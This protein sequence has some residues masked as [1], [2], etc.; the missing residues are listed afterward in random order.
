MVGQVAKRQAGDQ[1]QEH[2]LRGQALHRAKARRSGRRKK[3]PPPCPTPSSPIKNGDA[4]VDIRGKIYSPE[5][6]SA[7]ILGKLKQ[8]AEDY[9]GEP[10][11]EAV[12]TVPAYF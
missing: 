5:E 11:T 12:I 2:G 8:V 1:R 7:I 10:V 4:A 3:T 6:V 9:I